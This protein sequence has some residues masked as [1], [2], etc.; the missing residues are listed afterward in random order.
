M[1]TNKSRKFVRRMSVLMMA[2][3]LAGRVE[4]TL[5]A[6][7]KQTPPEL[8]AHLTEPGEGWTAFRPAA[9]TRMV[10]VSSSQ[11]DDA[12][13]GHLGL[14]QSDGVVLARR[15]PSP[16]PL[17]QPQR[18]RGCEVE[19]FEPLSRGGRALV[20]GRGVGVRV[21][22]LPVVPGLIDRVRD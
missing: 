10:F 16:Q 21:C 13:D 9:D 19:A 8:L 22:A 7:E 1:N 5:E 17:S 18:E 12:N 4:T 14:P 11:G 20:A 2:L 15:E 3:A 6:S